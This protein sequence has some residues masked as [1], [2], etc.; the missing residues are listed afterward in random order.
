MNRKIA[1][2]ILIAAAAATNAFAET[3]TV[4]NE[5]FVS[6]KSRAEVQAEL[7][8]FKQAGVNP[9]SMSYDQLAGFKS[10]LSRQQVVADYLGARDEVAAINGEDS[11]SA[12]LAQAFA[13]RGNGRA[14]LAGQPVNPQ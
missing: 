5:P 12:Y 9:W 1:S 13:Q 6:T 4:V 10:T 3:P 11:G 14:T 8:A 7:H 2:A